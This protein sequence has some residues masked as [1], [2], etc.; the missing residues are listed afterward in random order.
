MSCR[1]MI[2]YLAALGCVTGAVVRHSSASAD[3]FP[4]CSCACCVT[5][6]RGSGVRWGREAQ[7]SEYA[8][9][10]FFYG[11]HINNEGFTTCPVV[12]GTSGQFCNKQRQD[13]LLSGT[14]SEQVDTSRFCFYECMPS[15]MDKTDYINGMECI[16]ASV[17]VLQAAG[18]LDPWNAEGKDAGGGVDISKAIE[19]TMQ[20]ARTTTAVAQ[21]SLG[22]AEFA[23]A[24][25]PAA[26]APAPPPATAPAPAPAPSLFLQQARGHS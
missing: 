15:T 14:R 21:P 19:E 4:T 9:L 7:D 16:P 20:K 23:E 3:D 17:E 11:Q 18:A 6:S 5:Q 12:V 13:P 26:G 25:G 8:C 10:P 24:P 1:S 2:Q 22:D